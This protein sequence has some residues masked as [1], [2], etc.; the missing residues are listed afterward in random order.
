MK[1]SE[2]IRRIEAYHPYLPDYDG[3][4]GI[5]TGNAEAECT[6]IACALV[7]TYEVVQKAAELGCNFLYV[8]EPSFYMTPDYPEWR[9]N[10]RKDVYETKR[11]LIDENHIVIY[12]DHDHTHAHEPDGIFTGV[13]R[14]LGWE[15]YLREGECRIP[16]GYMFE[17]PPMTVRDINSLLIEKIGLRG[18]SYIGS[19]DAVIEK[20]G[21]AA[22]L[23][24]GAFGE[25]KEENGFFTD[26]STEIIRCM[27]EDGLQAIIP[28]EIIEWN[29]L[30]YISDAA[31]MGKP[32]ACFN[33]GHFNFEQL[34]ARFAADWIGDLTEHQIP[35]HYVRGSD[36][37]QYQEKQ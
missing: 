35:V 34:G 26:Y 4:D 32:C 15:K 3:C 12:R 1:I 16:Y 10:F 11:K 33:I 9:G 30:S 8:H 20:I 25:E 36:M 19:P 13:I 21:I 37:W 29:V 31:A 23:Y 2:I 24:P 17:I 7:P 14:Y 27:E 22:H 5:K 28:G 6:G 18:T